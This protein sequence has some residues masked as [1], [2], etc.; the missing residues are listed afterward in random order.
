MKLTEIRDAV[1][2]DLSDYV[3]EYVLYLY[4]HGSL[5]LKIK[6]YKQYK[7]TCDCDDKFYDELDKSLGTMALN[8]LKYGACIN[9]FGFRIEG[10]ITYEI[11][12]DYTPAKDGDDA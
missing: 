7:G 12:H 6:G 10:T 2:K 3:G 11:R 1:T 8:H 5:R 9:G 4:Q